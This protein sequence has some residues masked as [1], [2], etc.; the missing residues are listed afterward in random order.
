[1]V[2]L[3]LAIS[4]KTH[5]IY[6]RSNVRAFW[7]YTSEMLTTPLTQAIGQTNDRIALLG[8]S[9]DGIYAETYAFK[10]PSTVSSPG[11]NNGG[12]NIG[13]K[14][15]GSKGSFNVGVGGIANIADSFGMQDPSIRM[16]HYLMLHHHPVLF[17]DLLLI[18]TEHLIRRVPGFD[19]HGELDVGKWSFV[20]EYGGQPEASIQ[21]T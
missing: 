7:D 4:I 9:A 13:Y 20:S 8:F 6:T 11:I 14:H 17:K 5:L 2:L 12:G 19:A 16:A 10:G 1:M 15:S 18:T 3:P 21:R